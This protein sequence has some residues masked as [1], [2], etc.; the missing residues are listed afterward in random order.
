MEG[1]NRFMKKFDA[2]KFGI[3][4]LMD[5]IGGIL[6]AVGT[7]NFAATA[8]FPMVGFNGIALIFYHLF[9]LPIG[10]VAM[11]LNIPVAIACFKILGKDFFVRSVRTIIITS[12]IMDVIAPMFPVYSGDRMLA[13]ICTGVL[14]GLGYALIYMRNTSTGG[15]DFIMLSIKALNPHLSLGKISFALEA[16]V[17]L[18]GTALVS[19]DMDSLIYGMIISFLL[20]MVVDKVMYGIDAGKMTLI[21]TDYAK[22]VAERIDQAVGRG[23]TFLKATGSFSQEEKDV[24]LCACNNKEMYGIRQAVKEIDPKAFIIIVESNEVLGEGFKSH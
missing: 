7:Y 16:L 15:S 20:S 21:V 12:V 23:S 18:L 6:I 5:I 3:D 2:K 8:K 9:R 22:E 19:R 17:V 24:V 10:T 11:L 14:S 4:I 1:E 13:A